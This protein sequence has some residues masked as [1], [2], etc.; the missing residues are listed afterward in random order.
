MPDLAKPITLASIGTISGASFATF[1][2]SS[3][4]QKAFNYNPKWLALIIALIIALMISYIAMF[5]GSSEIGGGIM[6]GTIN[7]CLVYLTAIGVNIVL[8]TNNSISDPLLS[9][10]GNARNRQFLSKWF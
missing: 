6:I 7:G 1:V 9:G 4:I 2:I 8:P 5:S 3:A 10:D